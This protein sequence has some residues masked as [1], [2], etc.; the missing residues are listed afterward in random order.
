MLIV[1]FSLRKG[2][3]VFLLLFKLNG[4]AP[5]KSKPF[6]MRNAADSHSISSTECMWMWAFVAI[7]SSPLTM[8]R[9]WSFVNGDH[10]FVTIYVIWWSYKCG[11]E[12]ARK[13][14]QPSTRFGNGLNVSEL[15]FR[16]GWNV[17]SISGIASHLLIAI[18]VTWLLNMVEHDNDSYE[19]PSTTTMKS[20]SDKKMAS[21]ASEMHSSYLHI[22]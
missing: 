18:H 4:P 15:R 7:L 19:S 9:A 13:Q 3:C 21:F 1:T 6:S 12:R 2:A 5:T 8:P 16:I 11:N 22:R 10:V 20:S 14:K 17:F